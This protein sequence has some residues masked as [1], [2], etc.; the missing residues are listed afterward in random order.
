M[1]RIRPNVTTGTTAYE[2][3]AFRLSDP[4]R[5]IPWTIWRDGGCGATESLPAGYACPVPDRVLTGRDFDP[6]SMQVAHDG[7][8]WF[9]EEFG[10]YL[11]HTNAR[12]ELLEPPIPTPGVMSPS[13][14]TLGSATPNLATSKGYEGMAIAPNG[15]V[16]HPMLEGATAEDQAAGLGADLRIY[17]VADGAFEED[18]LRYRM[19][20]PTHALGDFIMINNREALV[21]ERDNLQGAAAVFKRIYLV[22]LSDA[23]RD[24]YVEKTLLVDLMDVRNPDRLGGFGA[25]FTFPY[26]TIE[27]VEILDARTIAVMNDNN[28]RPRAAAVQ[29]TDVNE[30]LQ[31]RLDQPLKVHPRLLP[32]G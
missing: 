17:T 16:L 20:S 5:H 2:G 1:H 15:R 22:D 7:T 27:D 29:R 6:E 18:L 19:E 25:T 32:R 13:N 9:G 31:I 14:P 8:L 11:L 30:Y 10:P 21:I 28:F 12:G 4:D 3:L 26:F 23:D 24:G